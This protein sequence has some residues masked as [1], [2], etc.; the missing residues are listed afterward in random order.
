MGDIGPTAGGSNA[1]GYIFYERAM[2]KETTTEYHRRRRHTDPQFKDKHYACIERY[3]EK[4]KLAI[5]DLIE[6]FQVGGCVYCGEDTACCLV[7][8]H[9]ESSKKSFNVSDARQG[10]RYS[11]T[12]VAA[13]LAKCICVCW[14]CHAKLHANIIKLPE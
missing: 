3:T 1:P 7:A 8:H 2:P 13:E 12:R 6:A 14:N 4:N 11:A 9:C 10:K 5:A